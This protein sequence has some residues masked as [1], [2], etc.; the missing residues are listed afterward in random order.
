MSLATLY[1]P[2]SKGK[3]RQWRVW[4]E[5]N[6]VWVEYGDVDGKLTRKSSV[7]KPKNVGKKN[8][9]TAQQQA[10]REA[11]SK[12]I[13]QLCREDY[14]EDVNKAGK[15]L[16]PQLALDYNTSGHQ[17]LWG[18]HS[19]SGMRKLDG[20]RLAY[21]K[22]YEDDA[23]YEFMTRKGELYKVDHME[24]P[25]SVMLG[26]VRDILEREYPHE[27]Y[28]CRGLDGEGY[29]HG[30]KLN[31][32]LSLVKSYKPKPSAT[33]P[34]KT[35]DVEFHLFDLYI[36]GLTSEERYWILNEAVE[37]YRFLNPDCKTINIVESVSLGSHDEMEGYHDQFVGEGY[38]GIIIRD[39]LA[40]YT[41]GK[42]AGV[43]Y[44]FKKFFDSEFQIFSTWAD[45]NG[46]IMF[47]IILKKG[48][49]LGDGSVIPEDC[50]C[51]ATPKLSHKERQEMMKKSDTYINQWWTVKYQGM[52]GEGKL[53]FPVALQERK[54]DSFGNPLE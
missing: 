29:I 46:C 17:V 42:H 20:V 28:I 48:F 53:D 41:E 32:I 12:W 36:D 26:L 19:Y 47:D 52:S 10:V 13:E 5:G 49:V 4:S 45:E 23:S 16:R 7:A 51:G 40:M 30:L 15:Q 33:N 9:T 27:S 24:T 14:H 54:C 3:V 39:D 44:K 22:R 35:E 18:K 50:V 38:E 43:M 25:C 34:Y 21:A 37:S 8:E 2:T 31:K 11:L 1:K 6:I